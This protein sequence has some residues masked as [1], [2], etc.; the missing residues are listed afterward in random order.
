VKE[1]APLRN[2]YPKLRLE[3]T[4]VPA[5]ATTTFAD[6]VAAALSAHPKQP[7]SS[8]YFYDDLGC[9]LFEA[10]TNLPEYYL[11]R[12]EREILHEYAPQ[13]L[14]HFRGPVDLVEL[15]SGSSYKTKLII[16]EVLR[17]QG[18]LHYWPI[19]ISPSALES[20]GAALVDA[21]PRLLVHGYAGDYFDVLESPRLKLETSHAILVLFLGSSIGNYTP[22]E[23]DR[24]MQLVSSRLEPGDGILLG[25]DVKKDSAM[26]E[27]AYDDETGV[28]AAFGKNLLLRMNRELDA[29]FRLRDFGH[30]AIYDPKHAVVN[31]YLQAKRAHAVRI[32]GAGIIA[33]F[34][35]GELMQVESSR[36]YGTTEVRELAERHG[37]T[38]ERTWHDRSRT[39]AVHLLLR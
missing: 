23:A 39:F 14:A 38:L 18:T 16:Q 9:A 3:L 29:S 24:L 1:L 19:D 34:G 36:K 30:V 25:A 11:T 12:A 5:T 17:K 20:S 13:M 31:C 6:A 10:I 4:N 21:F 27:R 2:P 32:P 37:L 7:V 22:E 26:L 28:M 35:D 33:E 15:G 8:K